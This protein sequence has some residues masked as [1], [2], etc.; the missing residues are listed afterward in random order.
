MSK[1]KTVPVKFKASNGKEFDAEKEATAY[2]ALLD[3]RYKYEKAKTVLAKCL[4]E[5]Q[6]T[7]DGYAFDNSA[8]NYYY[9]VDGFYSPNIQEVSF[10]FWNASF[11]GNDSDEFCIYK[12]MHGKLESFKIANL[13]YERA[14]ADKAL[15]A[16]REQRLRFLTEDVEKLRA[17]I[18]AKE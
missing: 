1:I 4:A 2:Q 9:I 12:E 10:Y 18:E 17:E 11:G 16:A 15:L 8:W 14:N 6:K 7:A 5:T 3:A 13:Y